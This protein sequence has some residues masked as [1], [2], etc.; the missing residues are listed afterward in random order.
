M[1]RTNATLNDL[2]FVLISTKNFQ[3]NLFMMLLLWSIVLSK[4]L[5]MR[6]KIKKKQQEQQSKLLPQDVKD[7]IQRLC[8][9]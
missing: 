7:E 4:H 9:A 2:L 8:R 6:K 3:V 1:F 5:K